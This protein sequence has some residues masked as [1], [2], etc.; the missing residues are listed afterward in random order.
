MGAAAGAPGLIIDRCVDIAVDKVGDGLDGAGNVEIGDGFFAKVVGDA[1]DSVALLNGVA[2][3]GQIAAVEADESDI[4]AVERGNEG[5]SSA[6]CSQHLAGEQRGDGVGNGVMHVEQVE[7]VVFGHFGHARGESEIVRRELEERIA[8]D[9][10]LVVKDAV[11]AAVEAEGLRIGDEM[12][13]VAEVRELDAELG[14]N[15]AR[16]AVGGIAG[17][18]DAHKAFPVLVS[19]LRFF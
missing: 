13:L 18:P 4:S 3:D 9:G 7:R 14:S 17:N 15:H 2:G 10:N 12:N 1:G 5:Q 8:G 11:V 6:S 19:P 16:A